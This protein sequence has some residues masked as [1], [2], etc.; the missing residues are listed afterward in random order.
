[1]WVVSHS[2]WG[3][4]LRTQ[5]KR[6]KAADGDDDDDDDGDNDDDDDDDD[7]GAYQHEGVGHPLVGGVPFQL[8]HDHE[9]LGG[10]RLRTQGKR[11]KAAVMMVKMMMMMIVMMM[12]MMMMGAYQHEGVGHPL[13]G[14]IPLHLG[15]DHEGLS[16]LAEAALHE[17]RQVALQHAT[18]GG[19]LR[20]DHL[21]GTT[22]NFSSASFRDSNFRIE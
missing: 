15:H 9:G 17:G 14:G 12:M 8:R 11:T 3:L 7:D 20:R 22:S 19:A 21:P 18:I 1:M 13:V 4:R 6:T 2:I 16:G 10:P 5:G